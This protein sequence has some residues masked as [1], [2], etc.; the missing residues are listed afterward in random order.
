M[1]AQVTEKAREFVE[2]G[3]K[4]FQ[5]YSIEPAMA[6]LLG[7]KLA[8]Y[9]KATEAAEY[10]VVA[11]DA[12]AAQGL[13][14]KVV[15]NSWNANSVESGREDAKVIGWWETPDGGRTGGAMTLSDTG[16]Y[17]G[18][19]LTGDDADAK[20]QMMTALLGHFVPEVWER[21][22]A[23][24]I[25]SAPHVGP[26]RTVDELAAA[27]E[28][29]DAPQQPLEAGKTALV[30]AADAVEA[31]DFPVACEQAG[32]AH[33]RFREAYVVGQTP[34]AGEFRAMWEH[35]G[36]GA[37]PGEGWAKSL[38]I[39]KEAG[40][41]AIVPNMWWGGVAHYDSEYLPHSSQFEEWGDA[42]EDCVEAAHERGI[43]VH[44]WKV[45]WNLSRAPQEFI[46][47]LRAAERLMADVNGTPVDWLC[48]SHPDNYQLELDTMVEVAEKYDVDGV[49]FDYIRYNNESVCYCDGCRERFQ[50]TIDGRIQA[51]PRDCHDGPLMQQYRDWRCDQIT[52]LVKA[53]SEKVREIKPWCKISAAVFPNYPSTKK[54]I[55]QD[56][57]L[58]VKED[59]LDFVCPMDYTDSAA[60]FRRTVTRQ[61][62]QVADVC[63]IYPGIGASAPGLPADQMI[64]QIAIAREAGADGF[65]IFQLSRTTAEDHVPAAGLGILSEPTLITSHES[66]IKELVP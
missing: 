26:F 14:E 22:S 42:I 15:Q 2:A 3:G 1:D 61:V 25:E 65:T 9:G 18:H 19:V 28:G 54:S 30:A 36:Y 40:F 34:R 20:G 45:N 4:V 41:N 8:G 5:F 12:D 66:R 51:W 13:P 23:R 16:V 39:L 29:Q 10:A 11:L 24:V 53:T 7:V 46:D 62:E 27:L 49:H 33:G 55:G 21:K 44:A 48:P 37:Y 64:N 57:L 58:W 63:P 60:G 47:E 56:W 17:L 6:E 32:E 38:D 52:R 35:S 31:R 59:Y 50:K 43:E